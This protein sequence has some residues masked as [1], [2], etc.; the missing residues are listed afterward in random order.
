MIN[1]AALQYFPKTTVCQQLLL[2]EYGYIIES[3]DRIFT[4]FPFKERSVREWMPFLDSIYP[5]LKSLTLHDHEIRFEKVFP[6]TD[7][8][9]GYYDFAFLKVE[10]DNRI[11]TVWS[12]YDVTEI[13]IAKAIRQQ[14]NNEKLLKN[15]YLDGPL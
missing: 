14:K 12:L 10:L 1:F 8:L 15:E 13:S 3:D 4:S 2:D 9:K 11:I 6:D 5:V 7:P